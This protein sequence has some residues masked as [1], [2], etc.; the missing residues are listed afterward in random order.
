MPPSEQGRVPG[1]G[2]SQGPGPFPAGTVGFVGLFTQRAE[3]PVLAGR[4]DTK[5]TGE[6]ARYCSAPYSIQQWRKDMAVFTPRLRCE[7]ISDIQHPSGACDTR[8]TGCSLL[9][10]KVP[11]A[12]THGQ[13]FHSLDERMG[14]RLGLNW[15]HESVRRKGSIQVLGLAQRAAKK[16]PLSASALRVRSPGTLLL[17]T[18]HLWH[19]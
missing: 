6:G 12:L 1:R 15:V 17:R 10:C 14:H 4:A 2:Q 19:Q 16:M 13:A 3:A 5:V 7:P 18:M 9:P 11:E 8:G